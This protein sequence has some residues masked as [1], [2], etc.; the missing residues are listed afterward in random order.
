MN[1][2]K[3]QCRILASS[4]F[5]LGVEHAVISPGSRNA[6]LIMAF[7]RQQGMNCLSIADERSA[8]FFALGMAQQTRK[9]V[10]LICTSGTAVLNYS[11]AI[12]E[13][14][15]QHIPLIVITADRPPEWIDQQDGQA[16]RQRDIYHNYINYH[17]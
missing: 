17:T 11:P 16:I 15:Y 10:V 12:A 13:A 8:A 2:D 5:S 4:L 3:K 6:P 7:N 1:T 14:Y 9:P